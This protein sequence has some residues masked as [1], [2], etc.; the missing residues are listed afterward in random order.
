[1]PFS[2]S[3]L[4]VVEVAL[5]V[6]VLVL[7]AMTVEV[8]PGIGAVAVAADPIPT[9]YVPYWV[10]LFGPPTALAVAS[11]A[12][13]MLDGL[14]VGSIVGAALAGFTL[15]MVVWSGAALVFPTDGGVFFGHIFVGIGAIALA[16]V[17][18]VRA[19]VARLLPADRSGLLDEVGGP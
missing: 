11:L 5:S 9:Q 7:V 14:T 4:H 2:R 6:A 10:V 12:G 17:V 15:L 8:V 3:Q 19:V 1:M 18:L 16:G 13:A